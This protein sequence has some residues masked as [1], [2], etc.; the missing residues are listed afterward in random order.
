MFQTCSSCHCWSPWSPSPS[1]AT[2]TW[3]CRVVLALGHGSGQCQRSWGVMQVLSP[4]EM[5]TICLDLHTLVGPT[6]SKWPWPTIY[7]ELPI[8]CCNCVASSAAWCP[9]R[10]LQDHGCGSSCKHCQVHW[11]VLQAG[12]RVLW[13]L[14]AWQQPWQTDETPCNRG[15]F[16]KACTRL[17]RR[18]SPC[19]MAAFSKWFWN[20]L[21]HGDGG[22]IS[23][24]VVQAHGRVRSPATT[25]ERAPTVGTGPPNCASWA[26]ISGIWRGSAFG[27]AL[28]QWCIQAFGSCNTGAQNTWAASWNSPEEAKNGNRLQIWRMAHT[29]TVSG[30][31]SKSDSPHGWRVLSAPGHHRGHPKNGINRALKASQ[32]ALGD[33]LQLEEGGWWAEDPGSCFEEFA[34]SRRQEMCAVKEHLALRAQL[35]AAWLLGYG[36]SGPPEAWNPPCWVATFPK[37]I[38]AA[39][40]ASPRRT[41]SLQSFQHTRSMQW[42]GSPLVA[43]GSSTEACRFHLDAQVV[44]LGLWGC[45]RPYGTSSP[46][47]LLQWHV[48]QLEAVHGFFESLSRWQATWIGKWADSF[49]PRKHRE[50]DFDVRKQSCHWSH[51]PWRAGGL[52]WHRFLP[53]RCLYEIILRLL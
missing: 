49:Y 12:F 33:S 44:F 34:A 35:G 28:Q 11:L 21:S 8:P 37:G 10:T 31:S 47:S 16:H 38:Q 51:G 5:P 19:F 29:G 4:W 43:S 53:P 48:T 25:A 20:H 41:N 46:S 50:E 24:I 52:G 7:T 13:C 17:P 45:H 1:R 30:K 2:C 27:W 15:P 39:I 40:G 3:A 18:P 22:R 42:W 26:A 32:G 23:C 9:W 14:C 36:S 6:S